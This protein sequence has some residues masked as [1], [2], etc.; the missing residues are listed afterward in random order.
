M[1]E[2]SAN[3][4]IFHMPLIYRSA[5]VLSSL[6]SSFEL[7]PLVE[8]ARARGY[9]NP[10]FIILRRCVSDKTSAVSPS[11]QPWWKAIANRRMLICVFTG[12]ASGMPLYVLL[13]LLPVYLR[14]GGVSLTEIGLFGLVTLPY[15]WKFLW[16]PL[17]DSWSPGSLGLRRSWML[18]T[19]VALL[20]CIG[21]LGSFSPQQSLWTIV[22][23]ALVV[24]LF[25]ASQDIVLDAYRRE[26]LPDLEL[27]M[28]NA[29]HV[30]AYRISSLVPGSLSLVLAG[31]MPWDTVFWITAAFMSLGIAMTLTVSEPSGPRYRAANW[32]DA[33]RAPWI[34]Y[35]ERKGLRHLQ[36]VLCF[37]FLY[38]LGDN[39]ATALST[40]F[41]L[42]LG[43][44]K[45]QIG[46][47]AKNAALWPSI[48]G[49][50]LGGLVMLR[51]GINRSLWM[52]GIV[53]LVSILGFALLAGSPPLLWL[54]AG[55]I[56]FE[57]FGV[58]LGTAAFTAFIARETSK[59]FAASQFALFT[60]LAALPRNLA[61]ATSGFLAESMGWLDFFLLCAVLAIPGMIMLHWVAPWN[62]PQTAVR[63]R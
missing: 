42:D 43:F 24:A 9:H 32:R 54:L 33:I 18:L 25:G 12:L 50:L 45:T 20:L 14:E 44:T 27:G 10:L 11:Q 19:Q 51:L 37:M 35:L 22:S 63:Y 5:R 36:L 46:L 61:S 31:S 49:G 55:V 38:K 3:S 58:G 39:M 48:V 13:Q 62:E 16:A 60:A 47:V 57:Y 56:A 23:V 1:S 34:E 59:T 52:F 15:T 40:V 21:L 53:Q 17:M 26:I 28:G 4:R 29:I 41:Y 2:I 8:S 7:T 30:Q 6:T